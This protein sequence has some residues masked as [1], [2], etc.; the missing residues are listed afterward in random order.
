[1]IAKYCRMLFRYAGMPAPFS[2]ARK[3]AVSAISSSSL[4]INAPADAIKGSR[5]AA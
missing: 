1:M 3:R 2:V 5:V 4:N